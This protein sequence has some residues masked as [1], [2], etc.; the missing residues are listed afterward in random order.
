MK[1]T[2][3]TVSP[4]TGIF[5]GSLIPWRVAPQQCCLRFTEHQQYNQFGKEKKNKIK[6]TLNRLFVESSSDDSLKIVKAARR[7]SVVKCKFYGRNFDLV[8]RCFQDNR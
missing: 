3:L 4:Q 8:P 5:V 6:N 2:C 7:N 1:K